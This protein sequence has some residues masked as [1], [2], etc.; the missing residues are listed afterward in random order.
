MEENVRGNG[1]HVSILD[2]LLTIGTGTECMY[3]KF[4][5]WCVL[6]SLDV[7]LRYYAEGKDQTCGF[8]FPAERRG[9]PLLGRVG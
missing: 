2:T 4:L 1:R 6:C 3:A 5:C 8:S 9:N 7:L